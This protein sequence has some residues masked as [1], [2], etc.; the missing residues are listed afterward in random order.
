MSNPLDKYLTEKG[1]T[2]NYL[3]SAV[4]KNENLIEH[5][6]YEDIKDKA[7]ITSVVDLNI[8]NTD[9]DNLGYLPLLSILAAG[10]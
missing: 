4:V 9:R 7:Q 2:N 5:G 8:P 3:I 6:L 1:D 10:Y